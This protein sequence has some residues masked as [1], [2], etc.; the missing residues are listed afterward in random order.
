MGNIGGNVLAN[1]LRDQVEMD[2]MWSLRTIGIL[3]GVIAL[4]NL[5]ILIDHPHKL[6]IVIEL[7]EE[8][9]KAKAD[10]GNLNG[11]RHRTN[12]IEIRTPREELEGIHVATEFNK[13]T[14]IM[15]DE[16]DIDDEVD[17]INKVNQ[18]QM[19]QDEEYHELND[20]NMIIHEEKAIS[21][22]KAWMIPGVIPYAL[23]IACVKCSTYGIL[24]WLP[25]YAH[26][27]LNYSHLD[28][29]LIAIMNDIGC[30]IGSIV[31]GKITDI[32]HKKRAPVAFIGLL[33]GT[34]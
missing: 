6:G 23:S 9:T 14:P 24:F 5:A 34:V 22:W 4:I 28:I 19:S 26:K 7:K 17:S 15:E 25:S 11:K 2:W 12:S 30:I 8:A 18:K 16:N 33:I 32:M 21:F 31:L 13:T 29:E 1:L 3:I 27:E 20:E 10:S